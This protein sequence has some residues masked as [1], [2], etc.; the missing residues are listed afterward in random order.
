M[1]KILSA[2]VLGAVLSGVGCGT[3]DAYDK[4]TSPGPTA[5]GGGTPAAAATTPELAGGA[6]D[7]GSPPVLTGASDKW[8]V[9]AFFKPTCGACVREAKELVQ[10]LRDHPDLVVVGATSFSEAGAVADFRS[11]TGAAYPML[12]GV[13]E[14]TRRAYEVSGYPSVRVIGKNGGIVGRSLE[15]LKALLGA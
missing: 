7:G 14:D 12:S 2:L 11:R 15:E 5:S 6:W 9:V 1:R 13:T 10:L 3:E 4:P 8:R